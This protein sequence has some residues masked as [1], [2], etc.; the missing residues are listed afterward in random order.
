M[1][2]TPVTLPIFVQSI[3]EHA[4]TKQVI[5]DEILNTNQQQDTDWFEDFDYRRPYWEP[6]LFTIDKYMRNIANHFNMSQ[7]NYDNHWFQKGKITPYVHGNTHYTN[8]YFLDMPNKTKIL[9]VEVKEGDL[10]SFPAQL[11]IEN[12]STKTIIGFN[13]SLKG[14]KTKKQN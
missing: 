14:F 12:D 9:N 6:F 2:I 8:V 13:I 10:L 3:E 7:F 1:K 4:L 5:L 11:Q